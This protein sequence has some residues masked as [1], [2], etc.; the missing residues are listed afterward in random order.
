MAYQM[1]P[2]EKAIS[3]RIVNTKH[4][5]AAARAPQN[6]ICQIQDAIFTKLEIQNAMFMTFAMPQYPTWFFPILFHYFDLVIDQRHVIPA[7]YEALTQAVN[8]QIRTKGT[9]TLFP[10]KYMLAW[11]LATDDSFIA[12]PFGTKHSPIYFATTMDQETTNWGNQFYD[13]HLDK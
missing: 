10:N 11:K 1:I 6:I 13:R 7:P 9:K 12:M 2:P 4:A 5:T 3:V 8:G